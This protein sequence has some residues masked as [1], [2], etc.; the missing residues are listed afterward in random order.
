MSSDSVMAV[1]GRETLRTIVAAALEA[2]DPEVAVH[3][4]LAL[5]DGN[6]RVG[7]AVF[8]LDDRDRVLVIGAGKAGVP[9]SR[10]VEATLRGLVYDGHV[11]VPHGQASVLE[12][13]QIHEAGHPVPDEAGVQAGRAVLASLAD[14]DEK[15]LV[16][17]LISGGGSALL[18]CPVEG[19]TL[20][21]LQ[22]TNQALLACG[23]TIVEIN[24]LRKHLSA[25]KGGQLARAAVPARMLTLV[26]SDVVGD[27]L[28]AIASGPTVPDTTTYE[29][30]VA[31]VDRYGLENL[32]PPMVIRRLLDGASG[33]LMETPKLGDPIFDRVTNILV[34]NNDSAVRAAARKADELGYKSLVL[35]T[36]IEGETRD[37]AK[38]HA[39]IAREIRASGRPCKPPCCLISGG[40][41][42][43]TLRGNGRGGRNQEF[44]LAA[45]LDIDGV[46]GI[47]VC[48]VGT[49]G[50]DGTTDAAGA[51]ADGQTG[52]RSI[53]SGLDPH[54]S[55]AENDSNAI[56]AA[57]GD[58]V[59]TGPT[60]TNVM[61]LRLILVD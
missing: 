52:A 8:P 9:M 38:V 25:V 31:I 23:A 40:E 44:V 20:E 7:D 21:D 26:L 18:V 33:G 43:V 5:G 29:D 55:L 12:R 13:I 60:D 30:C 4:H 2:V 53:A 51:I 41:T 27:P 42:T 61:D 45:A 14:A 54:A 37:V 10:A 57:L 28:D 24:T 59:V 3:H 56:F 11:I 58:L 48:S 49:D 36:L 6:I 17:C 1:D 50:I 35:S 19:V 39:A 15:T 46:G 16:I 47:T 32:L 22:A 34:A